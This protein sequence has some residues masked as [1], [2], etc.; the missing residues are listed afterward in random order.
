VKTPQ[1]IV[2]YQMIRKFFLQ[3]L[4][5]DWLIKK[6]VQ[7]LLSH[8]TTT[9][10]FKKLG[11]LYESCLRQQ[12]NSSTIRI[13]FEKL[14]GYIPQSHIGPT[15]VTSLIKKMNDMGASLI[16]FDMYFDLSYGKN[17]QILLMIDMP[18]DVQQILQVSIFSVFFLIY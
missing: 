8:N 10:M 16:L 11:R 18:T 15:S 4:R 14:G 3:V 2:D 7:E 13:T 9:G 6:N 1:E 12:L 5:Q 17:P